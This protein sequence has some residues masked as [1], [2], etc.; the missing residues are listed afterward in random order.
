MKIPTKTQR[1]KLFLGA[2]YF[3]K[4]L[5]PPFVTTDLATYRERIS[6][7]WANLS[8]E[9]YVS[10]AETFLYPRHGREARKLS[11]M[12]PV[13]F[14]FLS[15]Y[16]SDNWMEIRK[17]INKSECSLSKPIFD[18]TGTRA[19]IELNFN[20]INKHAREIASSY[21][22]TFKTDISRYYHTIYTH[23][24]PWC[25]HTKT[26][27]KAQKFNFSLVG[28]QLDRWIRNGQD[29]QTI[30]IPVGPQTSAVIA[31]IVGSAIDQEI[32]RTLKISANRTM[33]RYVDDVYLGMPH[34]MSEEDNERG[35]D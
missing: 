22:R 12:N 7:V 17:H 5:P 24:V 10:M 30:G 28:N 1:L 2:G 9:K 35:G 11:I 4:E 29:Q 25:L 34:L 31:E 27:A 8:P 16:I 3:P 32:I 20:L 14:Y 23:T 21:D 26:I 33:L 18:P 13:N 6:R 15:K 19:L